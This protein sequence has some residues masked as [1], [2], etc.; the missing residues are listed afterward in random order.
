MVIGFLAILFA[1][2]TLTEVLQANYG[3][4][5]AYLR[6]GG[7]AYIVWLA[8]SLF[9]PKSENGRPSTQAQWG[10]GGGLLIVLLNPKGILF[11]V[12]TFVVFAP[13]LTGSVARSF[14]SAA[15]LSFLLLVSSSLWSLT[16]AALTS[17]LRNKTRQAVFNVVMALLLL[18][19]AYSIAVH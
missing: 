15:F 19:A 6:W 4:L 1:S 16:G 8:V 7:V 2:A 14:G 17:A 9:L 12:T 18:L 13:I 5:S 11:A 3:R 10:F